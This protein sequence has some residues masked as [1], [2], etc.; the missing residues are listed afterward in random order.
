MKKVG[1]FIT[2]LILGF[3]IF[4]FINPNQS[5]APSPIS[6]PTIETKEDGDRM[7]DNKDEGVVAGN[8]EVPWSLVFLPDGAILVTE[9][10]GRVRLIDN[11]GRLRSG[12][13]LSLEVDKKTNGEGG[14]HGITLHPEFEKNHFVYLYYTYENDNGQTLNKVTRFVYEN[15]S[16]VSESTIIDNIPGSIFHDG[17]RIKFGPDNFLY[18]TTGDAQAPDNAQNLNSLSGKILRIKDDGGIPD[19]NP[20]S[21]AIF[22]YGHRNPQG[23][24]WDKDGRLWSTEHGRSGISS[25]LDELNLIKSGNN[26]GWPDIEGDETQNG[27]QVSKKNSGVSDTWAPASAA[28]YSGSIFF[29]GLRGE[30]LYEAVLDGESVKEIKEHY[31]GQLG[32]IRDVIIG[33]DNMLYL[34]TSNRDGRGKVQQSD[35]KII[36]VNPDNL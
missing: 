13:V 33:P 20:F 22:S 18:I 12:S 26:Y 7:I 5:T 29:G 35:D 21:N 16:L 27:M 25:G 36:R 10:P 15:N 30:A 32:R 24:V 31:K 17:G 19:D 4:Y 8:L 28:Y 11:K 9:R 1:V 23:I 6:L 2:I 3:L 14:L 34:T